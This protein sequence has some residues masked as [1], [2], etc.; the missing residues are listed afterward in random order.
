[1]AIAE[2][3]AIAEEHGYDWDHAL[4]SDAGRGDPVWL[5]DLP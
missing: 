5:N 2:R 4:P 1:M 3:M